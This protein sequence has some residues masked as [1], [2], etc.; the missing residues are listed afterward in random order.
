MSFAAIIDHD[1]YVEAIEDI[2][3]VIDGLGVFIIV[4]GT[5]AAFM[6]Y[7]WKIALRSG[8]HVAYQVARY[9]LARSIIFGLEILIAGDI[10]RTVALTP[11]FTNIGVLALIV[12]VRTFLAFSLETE[13]QGRWPWQGGDPLSEAQKLDAAAKE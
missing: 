5:V 12:L 8:H 11:T 1:R 7:V 13:V 9:R 3:L 10:I 2:G 6:I 4:V